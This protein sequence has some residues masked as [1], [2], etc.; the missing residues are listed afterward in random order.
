MFSFKFFQKKLQKLNV[1]K[2]FVNIN[3]APV[4]HKTQ[5]RPVGEKLNC[6]PKH[7]TDPTKHHCK[8]LRIVA[9]YLQEFF[10]GVIKFHLNII[11][12]PIGRKT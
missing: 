1:T 7:P 9:N 2:L 10:R 6:P 5:Q 12:A 8:D 3:S 11:S 4:G